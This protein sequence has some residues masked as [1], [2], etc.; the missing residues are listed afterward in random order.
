MTYYLLIIFSIHFQN[1]KQT[2]IIITQ[3]YFIL[4]NTKSQV[5]PSATL[6]IFSTP[7]SP[8]PKQN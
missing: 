7:S 1:I 8:F 2:K 6:V 5:Y 3:N 4:G